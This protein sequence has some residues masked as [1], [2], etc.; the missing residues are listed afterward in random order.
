MDLK[1][2][3]ELI[4][5]ER[6]K[7]NLSYDKI[8]EETRIPKKFL[9][10]IEE[11]NWFQFPSDFH[12]RA[13]LRKYLDYLGIKNININE[14]FKH[15]ITDREFKNEENKNIEEVNLKF[16]R[17]FYMAIIFFFLFLVLFIIS[18]FLFKNLTK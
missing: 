18:N 4:K 5:K 15:E 14:I 2:L 11:N 9:I 10:A 8:Y 17:S 16:D 1:S 12:K 7:Q 3:S 6:E 13:T